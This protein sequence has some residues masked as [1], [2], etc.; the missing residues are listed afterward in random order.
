[1]QANPIKNKD[2][3][4]ANQ[5]L[6]RLVCRHG[7]FEIQINVQGCEFVNLVLKQLLLLTRV[8]QRITST[9]PLQSNKLVER[10]AQ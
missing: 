5:S 8:E 9:Y 10:T 4:R 7:C 1:M 6:Y 3:L 2:A